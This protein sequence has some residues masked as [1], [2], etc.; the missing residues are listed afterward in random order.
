M[1]NNFIL[2]GFGFPRIVK[3]KNQEFYNQNKNHI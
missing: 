3:Q 1:R 2:C